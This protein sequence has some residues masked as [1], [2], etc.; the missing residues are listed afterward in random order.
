VPS[1]AS[2]SDALAGITVVGMT[3]EAFLL[4]GALAVG[5]AYGAAAIGPWVT[6][7]AAQS[8][9]TDIAILNFALGL[10]D[11][12]AAFYA[13][14]FKQ[15]LSLSTPV[16]EVV[17]VLREDEA[18]H[19]QLVA[20]SIRQLGV[21]PSRGQEFDFGDAFS[22]ED[23]FL[24]VAQQLE[25]T[26]VQAYNGAGPQIFAR[27]ILRMAGAIVQIEA[28]HA[29]VIRDLRGEEITPGAFDTIATQAE[30]AGRIRP[31]IK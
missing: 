10:E 6:G 11:L 13:Q 7:A 21:E 16:R 3:R 17:R 1:H 22:S 28:R 30:V 4:R 27:E 29:A 31:F 18:E 24:E 15:G 19:R 20:D 5:A 26:G 14:A 8:D 25:D 12:E 23:R 2:S 9:A